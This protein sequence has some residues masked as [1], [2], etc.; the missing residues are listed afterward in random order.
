M[1]QPDGHESISAD[2]ALRKRDVRSSEDPKSAGKPFNAEEVVSDKRRDTRECDQWGSSQGS[3]HSAHTTAWFGT[4][5]MHGSVSSR[6]DFGNSEVTCFES[7]EFG[8]AI[9]LTYAHVTQILQTCWQGH[10]SCR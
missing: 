8:L 1:Y 7:T 5:W 9:S 10:R 3:I 2:R 6:L 4:Y